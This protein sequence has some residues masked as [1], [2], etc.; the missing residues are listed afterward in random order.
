[1]VQGPIVNP[2]GERLAYTFV[3]GR[4]GGLEIVVVGH[5]LTSDKDRPWSEA[6]SAALAEAGIASLRVAFS[7]NGASQ[8][9]FLDSTITKEVAD[10]GAVLDALDGRSVCYVGHSMGA[11]VGALRAST[12]RRIR[13]LVS[14]AGVT[15]TAW[16]ARRTFGHLRAGDAMLGK[17]HCRWGRALERDLVELDTLT[18]RA[19]AIAVP[20]LLVHGSADELVPPAHS[21]DMHAA[22]PARSELVLLEAADH[23]FTGDAL[24]PMVRVVVDWLRALVEASSARR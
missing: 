23:S 17:P 20:W 8:G 15:H 7:G 11:A 2:F 19:A 3:P 12:D 4:A 9:S 6:L 24:A 22:A 13:A 21:L 16:F 14:L 5:G 1:V 18:D 10:L